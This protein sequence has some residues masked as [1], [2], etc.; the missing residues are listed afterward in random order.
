VHSFTPDD[1]DTVAGE[2]RVAADQR[3]IL[4]ESL[5]NQ[6]AIK[7]VSVPGLQGI[8]AVYMSHAHRQDFD[9]CAG[10]MPVPPGK[11]VFDGSSLAVLLQNQFPVETSLT[12]NAQTSVLTNTLYSIDNTV[13][14]LYISRQPRL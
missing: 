1:W 5:S 3:A 12:H 4:R 9:S 7:R 2:Q 11:W 13:Y 6:H 14:E 10:D 8:Q